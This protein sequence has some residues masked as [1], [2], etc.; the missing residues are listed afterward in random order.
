MEEKTMNRVARWTQ[1][2]LDLSL[3]NRLLNARDSRQFL[4]LAAESIA[5]LEDRLAADR[6]VAVEPSDAQKKSPDALH[7]GLSADETSRRLR[8]LFRIAKTELEESGVNALY[9]ALGFL[10]WR[11]KGGDRDYRAPILLMPVRLARKNVR[12]GYALSR[13]DEDTELNATLVEFLRVEFG[14]AVAGVDPLPDRFGSAA[15]AHFQRARRAARRPS[16]DRRRNGRHRRT[17][18]ESRQTDHPA[19]DDP[20]RDPDDRQLLKGA[21]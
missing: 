19:Q 12:E 4:P 16:R 5:E 17:F 18:G 21:D 7:S 15:G 3:R 14:V 10:K 8:E 11:P 2:L 13:L 9:L 1:K 6:P 20:D